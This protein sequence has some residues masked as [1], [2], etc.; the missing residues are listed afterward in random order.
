MGAWGTALFSDDT[1]SDVRDDY[2]DHVGDGLSGP[3][4]TD[5]LLNEWRQTLSDPD[6]GPVF[7]LALAATQ[8]KCGRLETRVLEKALEVIAGGSDL[9][10]WQDNP[11][12]LKKRQAV[13]VKLGEQLRSP[14]PPPRSGFP[15]VSATTATGTSAK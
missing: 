14:P 6:E 13:L 7:W 12:L 4:A 2:R 1:A 11:R 8:W 15:N 10:R 9:H 5:R 3:A